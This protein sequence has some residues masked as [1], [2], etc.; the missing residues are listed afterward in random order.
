M[1]KHQRTCTCTAYQFPHRAGGG[2]CI[3]PGDAP[4]SCSRCAYGQIIRD[5]FC[6]GD[7]WYS[8]IECR[9]DDCPWSMED[10]A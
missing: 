1:S 10:A 3:D 8:E 5:P 2:D 4:D 6:T 9:L 7:H